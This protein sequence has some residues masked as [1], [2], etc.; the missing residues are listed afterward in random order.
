MLIDRLD[1]GQW[2]STSAFAMN[3]LAG[4]L[5]FES[6]VIFAGMKP[7]FVTPWLGVPLR[8]WDVSDWDTYKPVTGSGN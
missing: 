5:A 3:L 4:K 1:N 2:G 7:R 6:P 8:T